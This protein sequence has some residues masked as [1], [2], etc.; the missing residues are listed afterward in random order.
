MRYRYLAFILL[1]FV[2]TQV[3]SQEL[4]VSVL[5]DSLIELMEDYKMP[6]M[7]ITVVSSDS[8][9]MRE[10]FGYSNLESQ[11]KVTEKHLFR[12]GS[13]SKSF[14]A[15]AV[16]KM[17][18]DGLVG[19]NTPLR[20]VAPEVPFTNPYEEKYPV[21]IKHLIEHKAGF[22][23]M[24]LAAF[25]KPRIDGMTALEEMLHYKNSMHSRWQPGLVHSYSNPGYVILAYIIEK[26]TG[27]QYQEYIQSKILSPLDM[28]AS[29][30]TSQEAM[31][32]EQ[33]AIGYRIEED[34]P[35]R[36]NNDPL[37]GEAAG[38]LIS[39][40]ED[41]SKFLQF[42]LSKDDKAKVFSKP[43]RLDEM[44]QLH[45]WLENEYDIDFGYGLGIYD[46][47]YGSDNYR[48]KGHSGGIN[49][50]LSD[51]LY[52]KEL[53]LGIAISS[54]AI[55]GHKKILNQIVDQYTKTIIK[56][57]VQDT[58]AKNIDQ[59]Y[60]WAGT[61][62][63][64]NTRNELF[65]FVNAPLTSTCVRFEKDT[66]ILQHFLSDV[67]KYVSTDGRVFRD[68]NEQR[69]AVYFTEIEGEKSI[70]FYDA[71]LVARSAIGIWVLRI[72]IGIGILLGIAFFLSFV[73]QLIR[74][75]FKKLKWG[76]VIK[77]LIYSL[78]VLCLFMSI[79]LFLMHMDL[80]DLNKLGSMSFISISI[81]IF[82]IGVFI[83][84][85][86]TLIYTITNRTRFDKT[87]KV[88][89]YGLSAGTSCFIAF[90]CLYYGW[91]GIRLWEY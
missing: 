35:I 23:D 71:V 8:I 91:I 49:G 17:I 80:A 73:V 53:D 88:I 1:F 21:L 32:N 76:I 75:F 65:R 77:N 66:M 68:V 81:F 64:L 15:L 28:N 29:R 34:A 12:V 51:Y 3:I 85:M 47:E 14:T 4:N 86:Y 57:A 19:L 90:Y 6:G 74:Y 87:W 31:A 27:M 41:M 25:T 36:A 70:Y 60:G 9:F 22:D 44:E 69:S 63:T 54:N 67:E 30:F 82:S 16:Q 7:F 83:S 45:G 37:I 62:T 72:M 18:E 50:F 46:R 42:F 26:L 56:G 52:S 43:G 38:A 48:F 78:P 13:I 10:G 5:R 2:Q 11:T 39:N 20:E 61:Y 59:Y 33:I 89:L 79:M 84:A 24:H 55:V 40:A 58:T